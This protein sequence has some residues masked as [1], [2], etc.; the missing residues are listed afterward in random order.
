MAVEKT[1]E[2]ELPLLL[3]AFKPVGHV[4]ICLESDDAARRMAAELEASG[5]SDDDVQL[6]PA[7]VM[8]EEL[9]DLLPDASG[10]AGFGWEIQSMREYH[11]L[12]LEGCG[13]LIVRATGDD[14]EQQV[15]DA[16]RRHGARLANKYNLLTVEELL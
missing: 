10:A 6:F 3:G 7:A 9:G 5:F 14:E 12:A 13:W 2:T 16:A 8:A 4:V 15:A 11:A 1:P